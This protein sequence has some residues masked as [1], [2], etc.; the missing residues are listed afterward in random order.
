MSVGGF[1]WL[2]LLGWEYQPS[3]RGLSHFHNWPPALKEKGVSSSLTRDMQLFCL[4]PWRDVTSSQWT[5]TWMCELTYILTPLNHLDQGST[6][7]QREEELSHHRRETIYSFLSC[8]FTEWI[9]Y[10]LCCPNKVPEGTTEG[11]MLPYQLG[12]LLLTNPGV[13]R[14]IMKE[15]L[16]WTGSQGECLHQGHQQ[17]VLSGQQ[18]CH[19]VPGNKYQP[20]WAPE[21]TLPVLAC[22]PQG[23]ILKSKA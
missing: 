1:S 18:A 15:L 23:R 7:Q 21:T 22:T 14:L 19:R 13:C 4:C 16:S 17:S 2:C 12:C 10:S 9:G 20:L 6:S 3:L 8:Y 11:F 5:I